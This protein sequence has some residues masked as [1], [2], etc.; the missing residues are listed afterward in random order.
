MYSVKDPTQIGN[1]E[2]NR[3]LQVEFNLN[4]WEHEITFTKDVVYRYSKRDVGEIYEPFEVLPEV[5]TKIGV[6]S[7]VLPKRRELCV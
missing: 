3:P 5:T 6:G 1:P 7:F 4:I 2:S